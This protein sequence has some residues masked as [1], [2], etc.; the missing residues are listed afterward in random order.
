VIYLSRSRQIAPC[1]GEN[2]PLDQFSQRGDLLCRQ[3]NDSLTV[4]IAEDN[5]DDIF[6]LQQAF[7]KAGAASGF[8][9]V[10]D[11]LEA[12][13]Y[14]KGEAAYSDRNA[15]PFPDVLLLDLNMPRMN[16]FELLEWIRDDPAC[17][18]LIVHVMTASS[19]DADVQRAYELG[20][21]SYVVK[22]SRVDELVAF[23]TALRQWHRF[24]VLPAKPEPH[25]AA[26]A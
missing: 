23:V 1:N 2:F 18:R 5:A 4:L 15:H 16:G 14:L 17:N 10:R 13:A 25:L 22:P 3:M 9:A 21:N 8:Q 24:T 19:R 20:A 6:L 26:R 7:K 12:Q 11:G